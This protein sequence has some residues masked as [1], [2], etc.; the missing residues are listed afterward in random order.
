MAIS[1]YTEMVAAVESWLNRSGFSNLQDQVP[2]FIAFGQRRIMYDMDLGA[3]E[4]I[5]PQFQITGQQ[6]DLPADFLR[7]KAI[8]IVSSNG[9]CE[10]L[11][12]PITEVMSYTRPATP[13]T[14]AVI[15]DLFFFGPPPDAT[16]TAFLH[17]YRALPI[18]SETNPE[19]WFTDNYPE[20]LLAAALVEALLWL[21][22]D[23]RAQIW[24]AQYRRYKD[25][26]ELSESREGTPAGTMK[27]RL[28]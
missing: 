8:N 15:N 26:L 5:V 6:V 1:N 16:Y 7:A 22:D 12:A 18:L 23:Q 10:V 20:L 21:K 27:A 2:D 14:F 28:K 17:Y 13:I 19:N 9:T 3:M 4:A 11:G 25:A 24:D